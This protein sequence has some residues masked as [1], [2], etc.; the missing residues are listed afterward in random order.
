MQVF[1]LADDGQDGGRAGKLA[2]PGHGRFSDFIAVPDFFDM[3]SGTEGFGNHFFA[4]DDEQ[5]RLVASL[6]LGKGAEGLDLLVGNACHGR[7]FFGPMLVGTTKI[8]KFVE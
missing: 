6:L 8:I 3:E 5:A 4:F 1:R 7:M 2:D